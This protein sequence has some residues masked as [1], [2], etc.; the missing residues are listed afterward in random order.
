LVRAEFQA[1]GRV[2]ILEGRRVAGILGEWLIAVSDTERRVRFVASGP[3]RIVVEAAGQSETVGVRRSGRGIDVTTSDGRSYSLEWSFG[4]R[5]SASVD[6]KQQRELTAPMPGLVLKVLVRA[7]EK[8]RV[9][10]TLVVLEAM[11]MEH[12]IEAPHDGVVKSVNCVE[13]G[14][15][16]EGVV[17]IELEPEDTK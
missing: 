15:V 6:A 1:H 7:G 17:L 5:H 3:E 2:E 8:V 10:Q 12:A 13:G 14:R 11:K 16:A 9:H 4:E